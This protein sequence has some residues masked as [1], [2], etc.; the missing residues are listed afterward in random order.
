MFQDY[1]QVKEDITAWINSPP[2]SL[3]EATGR[4]AA[5]PGGLERYRFGLQS[6]WS[7]C[8]ENFE[9][10]EMEA[11]PGQLRLPCQYESR[12]R[13]RRLPG[14][15]FR[16]DYSGSGTTSSKAAR[17]AS[18]WPWPVPWSP[19]WR[20][21]HPVSVQKIILQ[22]KKAVAVKLTNGAEIP[23][24]RVVASGVDPRMLIVDFLGAAAVGSDI[25][26]QMQRYEGVTPL[27]SFIWPWTACPIPGRA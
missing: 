17:T 3:A 7:W 27:L 9:A 14:L 13:R 16:H 1:L 25:I 26:R 20:H 21:P 2:A 12:G 19:G 24:T 5:A 15:A 4:L 6:L 22:S 11:L 8:D 18:P 23:V 10:P